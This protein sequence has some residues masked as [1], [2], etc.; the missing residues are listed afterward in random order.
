MGNSQSLD[1]CEYFS[2]EE[3]S[4]LAKRFSKLDADGNGSLSLDEFFSMPQL[5]KNPIARRVVGTN[6]SILNLWCIRLFLEIFDKDNSGEVDFKEFLSGISQFSVKSERSQKLEFAFKVYDMD[7]DGFISNADL[8][9]AL[10]MM[11]GSN[12][13]DIQLQQLVDKTMLKAD[14]DGDGLLSYKEFETLVGEND[15]FGKM[16]VQV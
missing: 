1:S 15:A 7:N 3:V 12:L 6:L 8:Y 10:K 11:A 5:E 14:E 4:R 13:N 16:T 2:K 9:G